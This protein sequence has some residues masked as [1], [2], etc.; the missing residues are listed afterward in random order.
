MAERIWEMV[1]SS[2]SIARETRSTTCSR[3]GSPH[4]ALQAHAD[5]VDALD[6]PVVEVTGDAVPVV[7]HAHH[8]DPVVEP[9]VLDG[10]AGGEGESLG[11][12]FVLVAE[13]RR[14]PPC[15]SGRGCRRRR[16]GPAW[17]PQERRHGRVFVGNP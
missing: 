4:G 6:D 13:R 10:D 1:S 16:L 2:S 8:A 17:D 3:S 7:E 14:R 11:Q 5:G 9:G 12:R 15:R